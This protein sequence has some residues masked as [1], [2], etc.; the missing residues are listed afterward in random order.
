MLTANYTTSRDTIK[1]TVPADAWTLFEAD[2]EDAMKHGYRVASS[3]YTEGITDVSCP[4]FDDTGLAATLTIPHIRTKL[5]ASLEDSL[6]ALQTS[7]RR[8][9]KILGG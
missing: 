6:L 7:A 5:S 8:L 2:A 1:P 9:S 3:D 4:V